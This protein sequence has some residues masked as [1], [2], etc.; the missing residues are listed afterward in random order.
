[1][2]TQEQY[3]TTKQ[4][5]RKL[6]AKINLLNYNFQKVDEWGNVVVGEPTFTIDSTSD[7]RRTCTISLIPID[8]SF[9]VAYGNKI[10]LDKYIQVFIGIEDIHTKEIVYDNMG[11]YMI[12]NPSKIYSATENQFNI[13]GIDL[14]AKLTGL[15]NGNLEGIPY[16]IEAG[17]NIRNAIISTLQLAGF[18]KYVISE[19][20][21]D[22]PNEININVGGT[23]YDILKELLNILPNHQMYFDVDGVFHCEEIPSGK[24]EQIMVDDDLWQ[25]VLVSY[26]QNYDFDNIKNVIE[27]FGKTHDV[28]SNFGNVMDVRIGTDTVTYPLIIS[29]ITYLFDGTKF[30]FYIEDS[31]IYEDKYANVSLNTFGTKQLKDEYGNRVKLTPTDGGYFVA[32]YNESEDYFL[33]LG[34]STPYGIAKEENPDSPFC[35]YN[36]LGEIRI[37]LSGDEYDNIYTTNLAQERA[38]WELYKRCRLQ[39]NITISCIPIYWLDV[40]WLVE[41]TLPNKN[42]TEEKAKYMITNINTTLGL[43]G[44]QS[45]QMMRYYPYYDFE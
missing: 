8:K 36:E 24:N 28:G 39:D 34:E 29:N 16:R 42:G 15:R 31:K 5:S 12:E 32:S 40:N 2:I 45:I 3:N 37:V 44:L 11:I 10:W 18:N 43:G 22:V 41:I 25:K 21:I 27:V 13:Q 20:P 7:I 30:G 23:L 14:M 9:D 4:R 35:I 38:K 17:S 19:F 1:M 33:F 6:Y 26:N